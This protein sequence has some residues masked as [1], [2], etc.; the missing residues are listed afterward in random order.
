MSGRDRRQVSFTRMSDGT[1]ADYELL[2]ALEET[3]LR[4]F[5]DRVL[6]WLSTMDNQDSGY[7]I[8]RLEHSLQ[9]ATRAHRAEEDEETVVCALLHD[10]GDHLAPANHSEVAAAMLRPYVSERN[11]WIIKHHG[12]FQGAYYFQHIGAD[13]NAR[14]RWRDHPYFQATVDFCERYD[15]VSFDP[16]YPSEP[17]SFFEPMLRRVLAEPQQQWEAPPSSGSAIPDLATASTPSDDD[18]SAT[19][20]IAFVGMGNLGV[21]LATSLHRAGFSLTLHDLDPSRAA[22]LV[23]GGCTWADSPALAANDADVLITCLPSPAAVETVMTGSSGALGGL[24]PGTVWI[25]MSTNDVA[26]LTE[27][28]RIAAS[29]GVQCLEAPVTG[30]VHLA[31][32]GSMTVLVGGEVETFENHRDLFRA[33]GRTSI[34]VGPLG[35]ATTVKV[36]TNMLAFIHL[37]AAGEALMLAHRSG[38][39]LAVAFK[40]IQASSGNSFVHETESQVLLNGSYDIGFTIDLACKDLGFATQLGEDLGVPLVLQSA[41]ATLFEQ[42]RTTYGGSAWSPMVVK[43]L[44]DALDAPLRAPGFPASL[45]TE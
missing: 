7:Q 2:S 9:A 13:P 36:I 42:A 11:Y 37:V 4:G 23:L 27:L 45:L 12:V 31:A 40:A 14:D 44:E 5:P 26:T 39:D 28:A 32:S 21:H 17:L 22:A 20:H 15:Q 43:L 25:D 33:V 16:A 3:D 35:Q 19:P 30:G 41:V 18:R 8:T 34:Y 10:I 38:I 6:G 29:V 24:A 1:A